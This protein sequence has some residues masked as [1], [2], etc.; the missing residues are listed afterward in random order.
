M[1]TLLGTIVGALGFRMRG[2]AVFG[3]LTGRGIGTARLVC[4][5]LPMALLSLFVIEWY[6]ALLF[7]AAMYVG[8]LPGWYGAFCMIDARD[9][10][11]MLARGIGWTLLGAIVF[12]IAGAPAWPLLF[13]GM[14]CPVAYA[15]GWA[16]PSRV[17][18]LLRGTEIGEFLFGAFIGTAIMLCR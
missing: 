3:E 10:L 6:W 13:A 2:S 12:F 8:S 9:W 16:I 4:W 18:W 14:L 15:I 17:P 5:A 7:C 1:L 11:V